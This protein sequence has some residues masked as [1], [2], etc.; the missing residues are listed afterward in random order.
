MNK[1]GR[2]VA[3]GMISGYNADKPDERYGVKNLMNVIVKSVTIRGFIVSDED[4]ICY[5]PEHRKN[6]TKW[7]N[8]GSLKTA[9]H[10]TVGMKGAAEACIGV[11]KGENFGKSILKIKL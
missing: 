4:M 10:E 2:I 1:F 3:C 7:L 9:L 6:V 11:L 8:D 5:F